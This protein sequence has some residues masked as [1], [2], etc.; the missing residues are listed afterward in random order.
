M[1]WPLFAADAVSHPRQ[2]GV[3]LLPCDGIK[4]QNLNRPIVLLTQYLTLVHHT[5]KKIFIF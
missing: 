4:K 2:P 1:F 3:K 5:K